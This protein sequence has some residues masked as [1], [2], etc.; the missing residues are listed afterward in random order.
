MT[1]PGKE[2]EGRK[3]GNRMLEKRIS[4]IVPIY[5]TAQY[6]PRCVGSI[7]EQTYPNLEIILVDDGSTDG[8]GEVCRRLACD[9]ARITVI[10]QENQGNNAARKS[11]VRA[12]TGDYI[13]FVD[14]D[15]WIG[16]ELVEILYMQAEESG[17]DMVIS[18][19]LMLYADGTRRERKNLVA[20]GVYDNAKEIVKTHF[21]YGRNT[22]YGVLPFVYSKLYERDL[23][24]GAME[25]IDDRIRFAED[26]AI[27]WTCLMQDIRVAFVD[28]MQYFYCMRDDSLMHSQD[29]LHLAKM[30]YFY[31]Y[32]H[33]LF[34]NEEDILKRQLDDYMVNS[35]RSAINWR[36]GMFHDN[37]LRKRYEF[38]FSCFL[39]RPKTIVLYGA[40]IVGQDYYQRLKQNSRI[41]ICAWVDGNAAKCRKA[42]L[43]VQDLGQIADMT[44]DCILVAIK[45]EVV[46]EQIKAVLMDFGVNPE[47]II[48]GKPY[49]DF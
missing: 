16:A 24:I 2:S 47:K 38:D 9:D 41:R 39:D 17:A 42:G 44:Y 6:L 33:R 43:D 46:Y 11:G 32:M 49:D 31:E 18:N 36:I 4:I 45:K 3:N 13:M 15:D 10:S 34:E 35:V 26:L 37:L 23:I 12:S 20:A 19:A 30:N 40:G 29:S 28:T 27:V 14:S 48:W 8:S 1:E 7:R 22:D 25:Q 5:N 21:Y